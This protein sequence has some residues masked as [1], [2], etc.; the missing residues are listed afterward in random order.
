MISKLNSAAVIGIQAVYVGIEVEAARGLPSEQ[1]VGLPD[2]AIRESKNRI[3]AA[4]KSSGF[5]YPVMAFTINLS[6]ADLPKEGALFDLPIA[7]AMLKATRQL[8]LPDNV[9]LAGE[10]GLDGYVRPIRG[11]VCISSMVKNM[12]F[13]TL[14]LPS[15]NAKEAALIPDIDVFGISSLSQLTSFSRLHKVV[16]DPPH[17]FASP[18]LLD[19]ADVKGQFAAK[20]A[21]EIAATGHHNI[22][23]SGTPGSG[24]SMLLKRLPTILPPLS[25]SESIDCFKI[26]SVTHL[27]NSQKQFTL[28]RPFRSPHHSISYAAMVGGGSRALPGEI[29]KSHHGVLFLDEFPEFSRQVIESLR[30]PLEDRHITIS[31]ANS[32]MTYPANV[33]LAASMNPCPC[34]FYNDSLKACICQPSDIQRYYR[35]ISGPISDRIDIHLLIP[36]LTMKDFNT[37][38]LSLQSYYTSERMRQRILK[39][40]LFQSQRHQSCPNSDLNESDIH[41][42]CQLEKSCHELLMRSIDQGFISGRSYTSVLKLSRS[43][44]DL[45][46]QKTISKEFLLEAMQ[47]KKITKT[48]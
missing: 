46:Q 20:R 10:L 40:R 7:A 30:Q 36:R 11:A 33:L 16:S 13:K 8:V 3:K 29:T 6:P 47:Y 45:D 44:A 9:F 27:Y 41:S 23:F 24:K 43:I 22:L 18:S 14:L 39:A 31:R 15:E 25:D 17:V 1:I 35:K 34:G 42:F 12:G 4:I 38:G 32:S 2:K 21:L 37:S 48:V 28:S 26:S 5:R 19:F